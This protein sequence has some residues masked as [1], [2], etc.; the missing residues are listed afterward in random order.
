VQSRIL[1]ELEIFE[2]SYSRFLENSQISTLN[3][4]RY[5]QN[6]SQELIKLIQ[7]GLDF[8]HK[9]D[10]YFNPILGGVLEG[11]GYDKDYSFALKNQD[12]IIDGNFEKELF[13]QV[14]DPKDFVVFESGK[15]SFAGRG[16]WDLGG[17]GKGFLIDKIG[18]ILESEFGLKNFLI[19]GGGDILVRGNL[20]QEIILED[21]FNPSYE[22]TKITLQNSA[23][24]AS[25]T[26]KRTWKD[27]NSSQIFSHI[28]NPKK[29]Q[30]VAN[31]ASF[32]I[33][34]NALEA[35]VLAT[36]ACMSKDNSDLIPTL[37]NQFNFEHLVF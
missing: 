34:K 6:P 28:L 35:D 16:N 22:L 17:Y 32:V 23:L 26:Q 15:I 10:G 37:K 9:T 14:S 20:P 11:L 2:K 8:Y 25:S 29:M 30:T 5:L 3:S 18:A 19:N 27:T 31:V 13:Q 12:K 1:K 21:P 24:G 4:Q 7:I 36:L 33:A